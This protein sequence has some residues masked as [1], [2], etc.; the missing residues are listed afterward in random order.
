MILFD[1]RLKDL[2]IFVVGFFLRKK[3]K[4]YGGVI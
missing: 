4:R 3:I 2:D 1:R